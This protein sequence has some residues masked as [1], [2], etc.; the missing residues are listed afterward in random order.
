VGAQTEVPSPATAMPVSP[1]HG[2]A[3]VAATSVP[4][5][6]VKAPALSSRT[7]L[8]HRTSELPAKRPTAAAEAKTAGAVALNPA[9][10]CSVVARCTAPQLCQAFSTDVGQTAQTPEDDQ[11]RRGPPRPA[12]PRWGGFR[13][14]MD[15]VVAGFI[16]RA[17]SQYEHGDGNDRNGH[18]AEHQ[19]RPRTRCAKPSR[20][21]AGHDHTDG[22]PSVREVHHGALG[23]DFGVHTSGVDRYIGRPG[24]GAQEEQRRL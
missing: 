22:E 9:L 1:I 21:Q 6:A 17:A 16:A 24:C 10:A 23:A 20:A 19:G 2:V 8:K 5:P 15:G 7:G 13:N 11:G 18:R 14:E 12:P 4:A 3:A